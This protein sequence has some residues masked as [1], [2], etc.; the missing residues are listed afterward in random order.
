[1]CSLINHEITWL[2][3]LQ[4]TLFVL[5]CS[6]TSNFDGV[7]H[8]VTWCQRH[9]LPTDILDGELLNYCM[10][11]TA[12]IRHERYARAPTKLLTN[13]GPWNCTNN[14]CSVQLQR[15]YAHIGSVHVQRGALRNF[16][17]QP[18]NIQNV[19]NSA[20]CVPKSLLTALGL[21][22]WP[23]KFAKLTLNDG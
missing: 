14:E 18:T 23:R 20:R 13:F 3:E 21:R 2:A 16:N 4:N 1:M 8:D 17:L 19:Q 15:V 12:V 9:Q 10:D 11:M 6:E 22:K 7:A 5:D